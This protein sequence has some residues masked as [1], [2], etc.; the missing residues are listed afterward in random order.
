MAQVRLHDW[1]K[2]D[3]IITLYFVK[4]DTKGLPVKDDKD[5]AEGVI[6]ASKASLHM[7]AA[8]IRYILGY[9]DGILDC[10]SDIQKEV[11]DQYNTKT[12]EELKDIV[13]DIISKRDI[14]GNITKVRSIQKQK[15]DAKKKKEK[16]A[17]AQK[18]M[19]DMWRKMGKDPAKMKL[20]VKK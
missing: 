16:A 5:L 9:T 10:Y 4:F 12:F 2:D 19:D 1:D 15:E 14:S 13:V 7:Q 6:G 17:L 3:T 18:E 20:V 11:V 8:N